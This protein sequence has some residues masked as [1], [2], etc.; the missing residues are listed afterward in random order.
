MKRLTLILLSLTLPVLAQAVAC[1]AY[2]PSETGT[3]MEQTMYNKK[4]KVIGTNV[5]ELVLVEQKDEETH[6]KVH[7]QSLDKKGNVTYE[8]DLGYKCVDDTFYIDMS[9]FMNGEAMGAYSE[10]DL[11][12]TME[13]IDIPVN[14]QP[15]Q[16]LKDGNLQMKMSG[17]MPFNMTIKV[18]VLNRKVEAVESITTPAGTFDCVKISQDIVTKMMMTVKAHSV[19]WYARGVG[20]VRTES[21]NKKGKLTG[22]TELTRLEKP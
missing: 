9:S 6:F 16:K 20:V 22:Y 14:A 17:G 2:M 5:M 15:G 1:N 21:Y 7:Q 3:V 19:D 13:E 4:G 8:T 11:S 12:V 10:M 18:D